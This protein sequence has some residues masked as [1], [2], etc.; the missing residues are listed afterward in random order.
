MLHEHVIIVRIVHMNVPHAAPADR[1]S[2]DDIGSAADGIVHMSI[3]VGFTDDQ[4]IP[5]N[6]ALAVDQTPELHI[7]LDQAL[8]F[9]SV[10]TLRPPR[11]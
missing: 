2:V 6:L 9:L 1:I 5:R 4:D 10:L 11:A 3:R 8:Y 7:D